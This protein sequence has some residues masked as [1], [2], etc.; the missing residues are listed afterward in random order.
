V[1]GP[2]RR[3]ASLSLGDLPT[4][5]HRC[6]PW[7]LDDPPAERAGSRWSPTRRWTPWRGSRGALRRTSA[8]RVCRCAAA[9]NYLPSGPSTV[10]R[11]LAEAD[12]Q[13]LLVVNGNVRVSG[14]LGPGSCA[15]GTTQPVAGGLLSARCTARGY[16]YTALHPGH[17]QLPATVRPRCAQAPPARNGSPRRSSRSPSPD[18]SGRQPPPPGRTVQGIRHKA[19]P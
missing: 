7:P 10:W 17:G 1:T 3:R 11:R 15:R 5:G 14:L 18:C 16:R 12:R 2:G 6:D 13:F 19:S 8:G 9:G 4:A